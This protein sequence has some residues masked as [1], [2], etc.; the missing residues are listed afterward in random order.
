MKSVSTHDAKTHLSALLRDVERGE[1]IEIR[2]GTVA[3]ARLAPIRKA[4]AQAPSRPRTGTVTSMGVKYDAD[5]FEPLD[6]KALEEWGL[7]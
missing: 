3:I 2:R 5:A 6:E 4:R 1:E 7:V